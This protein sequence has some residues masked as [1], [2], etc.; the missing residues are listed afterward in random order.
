[1]QPTAVHYL[2]IATTVISFVFAVVV[3]RRYLYRGGGNHLL[4]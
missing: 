4:W 2:P 3:Y 1:M